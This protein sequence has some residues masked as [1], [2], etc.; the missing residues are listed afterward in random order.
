[1][2]KGR[3]KDKDSKL[4]NNNQFQ[5][6]ENKLEIWTQANLTQ[7]HIMFWGKRWVKNA[8][9]PIKKRKKTG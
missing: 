2:Y 5:T 1:M 8:A 9:Q 6:D 4:C 7:T 3:G